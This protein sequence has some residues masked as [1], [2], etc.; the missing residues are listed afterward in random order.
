[1]A[2]AGFIDALLEWE[3]GA[4]IVPLAGA[5]CFPKGRLTADCWD[6]LARLIL[7]PLKDALQ[8]G[9]VDGVLLCL[10]GALVAERENDAEGALLA[11]VRCLVGPHTAVVATLDLHCHITQLMLGSADCF[12]VYH[13]Y[14]HIGIAPLFSFLLSHDRTT[15]VCVLSCNQ[16]VPAAD[17]A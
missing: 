12:C 2:A 8:S 11:A 1:M 6:F 3:G 10:H 14:P 9:P 17:A 4:D 5:W 16:C 7:D 15:F 13:T